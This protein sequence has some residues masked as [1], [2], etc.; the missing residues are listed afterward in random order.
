[1]KAPEKEKT[2]EQL[3]KEGWMDFRSA[4]W[5]TKRVSYE[6]REILNPSEEEIAAVRKIV[7][8]LNLMEA[9]KA[10]EFIRAH[11][12]RFRNAVLPML[13]SLSP[14]YCGTVHY[15]LYDL[16]I[17]EH[18]L[19]SQIDLDSVVPQD[20]IGTI[21]RPA[22]ERIFAEVKELG[23][24]APAIWQE[25]MTE[26]EGANSQYYQ[27]EVEGFTG[28]VERHILIKRL[29]Q[30]NHWLHST[31]SRPAFLGHGPADYEGL[32]SDIVKRLEKIK[33]ERREKEMFI[34]FER[35]PL[36]VRGRLI[37]LLVYDYYTLNRLSPEIDNTLRSVW[38]EMTS[39][40]RGQDMAN[41]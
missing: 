24:Q 6:T 26:Y 7:Q 38:S 29:K 32:Y 25:A 1:M 33:P 20:I 18:S 22:A 2:P 34:L 36:D 12:E 39:A 35:F 28:E 9:P 10:A 19:G 4:L 41:E 27:I 30:L 23:D 14:E 31:S 15:A 37:A 21:S 13:E 11:P 8:A 16:Y 5:R 40:Q 17:K 3:A